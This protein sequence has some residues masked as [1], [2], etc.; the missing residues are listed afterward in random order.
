MAEKLRKKK[1]FLLMPVI[2][3]LTMPL[4]LF[5]VTPVA[6]TT[7]GVCVIVTML[8]VTEAVVTECRRSNRVG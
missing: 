4:S 8:Q 3:R 5:L 6:L 1:V 2:L 7:A